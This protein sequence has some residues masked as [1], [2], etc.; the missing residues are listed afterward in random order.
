MIVR[1]SGVKKVRAKGR[2]YY[3]HR[4]TNTR[5]PD[6]PKSPAFIT[7]LRDLDARIDIAAGPGT[8][9][10]LIKCYR[11]SPEWTN[12]APKTHATYNNVIDYLQSLD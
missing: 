1:L 4:Q 11:Q 3:Y 8:L 9:G 7:K 10:G 2:V 6:D 12:L 5:L